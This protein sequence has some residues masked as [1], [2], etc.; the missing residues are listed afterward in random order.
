LLTQLLEDKEGGIQ[1]ETV[2]LIG[3]LV[4][5]GKRLSESIGA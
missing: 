2:E 1:W 3:K 4:N 5:H